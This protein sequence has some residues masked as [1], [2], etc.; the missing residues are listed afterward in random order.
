MTHA[1]LTSPDQLH[2]ARI[3]SIA[4]SAR[5][6]VDGGVTITAQTGP[7]RY[8]AVTWSYTDDKLATARYNAV[9]QLAT[10]GLTAQEIDAHIN[11]G[12]NHAILTVREIF[13]EAL[14][15]TNPGSRIERAVQ[16]ELAATDTA[17]EKAADEALVADINAHLDRVHGVCKADEQDEQPPATLA[18]LAAA[19]ASTH[20]RVK[21]LAEI[22]AER[23]RKATEARRTAVAR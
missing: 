3:G 21:T 23:R 6:T 14:A 18:T 9:A 1:V 16:A 2:T 11:G 13:N 4:L 17:A 20:P 8:D 19:Y 10:T 5:R 7:D 15:H 12:G 22:R